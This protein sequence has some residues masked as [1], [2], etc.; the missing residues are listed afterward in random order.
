MP[1]PLPGALGPAAILEMP[2]VPAAIDRLT[3]PPASLGFLT[4]LKSQATSSKDIAVAKAYVKHHGG[5]VVGYSS[6]DAP[7]TCNPACF[8]TLPGCF[9]TAVLLRSWPYAVVDSGAR[10][11]FLRRR[12]YS[13]SL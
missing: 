4:A 6:P 11:H 9:H 10:F 13:R 8:T 12:K 1:I 7:T 2:G 3:H 5:G